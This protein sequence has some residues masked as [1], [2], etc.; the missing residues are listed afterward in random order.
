MHA[1]AQTALQT[2]TSPISWQPS[3]CLSSLNPNTPSASYKAHFIHTPA[4]PAPL[5]LDGNSTPPFILAQQ[6]PSQPLA[7]SLST[8]IVSH[9]LWVPFVLLQL[10]HPFHA[11]LAL[12]P[13]RLGRLISVLVHRA[14][15][16]HF[17]RLALSSQLRVQRDH[18][19]QT[20][21]FK[22]RVQWVNIRPHPVPLM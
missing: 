20:L 2:S 15:S 3:H 11:Q 22:F 18:I 12:L 5:S 9:V 14:P 6:A 8:Q 17:V 7:T 10:L 21:P 13:T 19:A 16:A 1:Y 4:K